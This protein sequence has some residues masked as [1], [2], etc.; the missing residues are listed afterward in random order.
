MQL[1][2]SRQ[3][4]LNELM[5]IN[6]GL[7]AKIAHDIF[8]RTIN[9]SIPTLFWE[10]GSLLNITGQTVGLSVEN[11]TL[12]QASNVFMTGSSAKTPS[13]LTIPTAMPT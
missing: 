8:L 1:K 11:G 13:V 2:K 10:I 7:K 12:D 5:P 4:E 9:T 3:P 6:L